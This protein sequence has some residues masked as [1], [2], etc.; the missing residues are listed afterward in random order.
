MVVW[1]VVCLVGVVVFGVAH[2]R[3]GPLRSVGC[4]LLELR[5]SLVNI[6]CGAQAPMCSEG[7]LCTWERNRGHYR[8]YCSA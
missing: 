1:G 7:G 5:A 8:N 2:G 3:L 4:S 6:V